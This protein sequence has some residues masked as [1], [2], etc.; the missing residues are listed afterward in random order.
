MHLPFCDFLDIAPALREDS[1]L[2]LSIAAL[3]EVQRTSWSGSISFRIGWCPTCVFV[4]PSQGSLTGNYARGVPKV[5]FCRSA[6][7]GEFPQH[8]RSS[9]NTTREDV[10]LPRQGQYFWRPG[11]PRGVPATRPEFP[12]HEPGRGAAL[13]PEEYAVQP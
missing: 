7:R 4:T 9:R 1:R 11:R 2:A 5:R 13:G 3:Q 12:L 8:A 6:P 10:A